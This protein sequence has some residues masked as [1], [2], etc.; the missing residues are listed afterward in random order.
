MSV[1]VDTRDMYISVEKIK[2]TLIVFFLLRKYIYFQTSLRNKKTKKH[3][4]MYDFY[5]TLLQH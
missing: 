3:L 2:K 1:G 4:K 5:A